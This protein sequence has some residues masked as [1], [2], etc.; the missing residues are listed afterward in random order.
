MNLPLRSSGAV[1]LMV[2]TSKDAVC[3]RTRPSAAPSSVIAYLLG[4]KV[5]KLHESLRVIFDEQSLALADNLVA[6]S[7][8]QRPLSGQAA[9]IFGIEF[10]ITFERPPVRRY[11]RPT[12]LAIFN[13][14][15]SRDHGED[16]GG[17]RTSDRRAVFSCQTRSDFVHG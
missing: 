11:S 6:L 16:T 4:L 10:A 12:F 13:R 7:F 14:S 15:T 3:I 9:R 17:N 1:G 2:A 8:K 5:S